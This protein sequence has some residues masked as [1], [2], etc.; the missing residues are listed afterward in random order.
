MSNLTK[1][2]IVRCHDLK[3]AYGLEG[4]HFYRLS[5]GRTYGCSLKSFGDDIGPE[6]L[7]FFLKALSMQ[8]GV[9]WFD[10]IGEYCTGI[11]ELK[12]Q[13]LIFKLAGISP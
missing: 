6:D 4:L 9:V 8:Q 7:D 2:Q 5:D 11:D 13:Y 12:G 3:A 10:D 1:E